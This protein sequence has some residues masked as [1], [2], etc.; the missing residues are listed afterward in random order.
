MTRNPSST[1]DRQS[2][3]SGLVA[4]VDAAYCDDAASGA[5]VL[6]SGFDSPD[7]ETTAQIRLARH[8]AGYEP[9]AFY[10]RELPVLLALLAKVGAPLRAIVIDGYVFLGRDGRPGLG[11]R[12]AEALD[13]RV[14]V[15]GV[16]KTPFRGDDWS[17]PVFRGASRRPLQVTATGIAPA[18]AARA[19]TSMHGSHRIPAM[20]R[21]A[22]RLARDALDQS[23]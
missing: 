7:P 5:C 12:L 1:S 15:I 9:G 4:V 13:G 16:A 19:V 2:P 3:D 11:A 6:L 14:P 22:D 23:A 17:L 8:S 10:K 20:C 21:L 18:V